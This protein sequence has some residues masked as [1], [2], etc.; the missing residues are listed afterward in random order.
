MSMSL[1]AF[2]KVVIS[3]DTPKMHECFLVP[4]HITEY[5]LK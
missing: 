5:Y 3:G 2:C 1:L 4:K